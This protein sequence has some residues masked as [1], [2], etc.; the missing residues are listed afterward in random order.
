MGRCDP[1]RS[2]NPRSL[3]TPRR[4]DGGHEFGGPS[5]RLLEFSMR[6]L[7]SSAEIHAALPGLAASIRQRLGVHFTMVPILNGGFIFAADLGR[8]LHRA[9]ADP[10]IDFVQVS[11]YGAGR[12]SSGEVRVVKDLS[13]SITGE[14]VLLVDDVLDTGRSVSHIRDLFLERGAAAVFTCVAVDKTKGRSD[15]PSAEFSLFQT[16]RTDFLV[17][18]G[19]DDAGARR[20]LPDIAVLE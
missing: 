1:G 16:D 19:M 14:S 13:A 10:E 3:L 12:S 11:S 2:R 9:G 8:A 4:N 7:F 5:L 15:I 6:V 20:T 17:G 18:Y